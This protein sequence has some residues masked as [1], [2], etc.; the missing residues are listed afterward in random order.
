MDYKLLDLKNIL[1]QN[2]NPEHEVVFIAGNLA[3]F[4][5]FNSNNKKDLLDLIIESIMQASNEK[6]TIMTQTMSFQICNT[7]IPFHRYTWANLGAFG[8]YLL[9]LD[10]SIRSLHPFA[11]YTAF[12]KNA[13][14]CNCQIP[15]AY[16]LQSPYD[17]M[18]KYDNIL[19]I[20]MGMKPNLTC[21]IVHHAEFNMHV[22]Y[23][24]IK[25]F[26]HP[27]QINDE[28]TYKKFYLHVLYKEY[29]GGGIKEI[30]M[31]ISLIIFCIN[32]KVKLKNFL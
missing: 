8:N 10:G 6:S 28:I 13:K 23:R 16:G 7:D 32:I 21:S 14:I 3:N 20:S 19:M 5:R 29:C 1:T 9:N 2:I 18:L 17:N 12:G 15:F 24:Y 11:S 30:L 27:I 4:G 22:P 26:N 25:E 31:L